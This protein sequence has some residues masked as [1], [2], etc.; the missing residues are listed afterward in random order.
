MNVSD[1]STMEVNVEVNESDIVRIHLG[2][3]AKSRS[4]P[5]W[6]KPSREPSPK[7]GTRR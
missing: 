4:T 3:E 1:L 7:S 6:E 2:D 5:T